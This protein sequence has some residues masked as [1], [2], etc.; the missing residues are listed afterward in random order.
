MS[1]INLSGLLNNLYEGERGF[2][3][4]KGDTG[5]VGSTGFT[6]SKGELVTNIPPST[7]TTITSSD[8]GKYLNISAGVTINSS[9]GFV[10]GDAVS[11][12]NSSSGNITITATGVT[13]RLAGTATTGNRTLAQKGLVTILCVDLNDYVISGAGLT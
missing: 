7:N 2:T 8:K 12:Y 5:F 9:T 3:G 11:I 6:G 10:S 13:L 1:T 4:S